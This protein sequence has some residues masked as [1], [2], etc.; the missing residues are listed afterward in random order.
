[1]IGREINGVIYA[2]MNMNNDILYI[3]NTRRIQD[4]SKRFSEHMRN[5]KNNKHM[6]N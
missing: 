1:M 2:I 6:E 5:I 3:G 4:V